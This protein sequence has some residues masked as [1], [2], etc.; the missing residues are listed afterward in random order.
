MVFEASGP[1]AAAAQP[2]LGDA[3]RVRL[4]DLRST[5]EIVAAGK[6]QSP[7]APLPQL[8]GGE[9]GARRVDVT[10]YETDYEQVRHACEGMDAV[11]NCTVLRPHPVL[12]FHVNPLGA[13][14]VM[15]AAVACGIRRVVHT[16]PLQVLTDQPDGFA[17]DFNIPDEAPA[18]PGNWLYLHS[19]Y[20]GQEIVRLFAQRYA[21]EVPALL[22][23][24]FVDADVP[25]SRPRGIHPFTVSWRDP[26]HA[27]AR[28]VAVHGL[29]SPFEPLH[30]LADL[31]RGKYTNER[32]KRVLEWQ[33]RDTL[34]DFYTVP[35]KDA[36]ANERA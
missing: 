18:R 2:L 30:I 3:Y 34:R 35:P 12:A 27:V 9:H 5:E 22:F 23:C 14:H 24:G 15:K 25:Q 19:K 28:A 7:S 8:P 32:A 36:R 1:L 33:P 17:W 4:T 20:L 11:V 6:P 26:G 29:P 31:P 16:G 13:Y 21:L 10:D